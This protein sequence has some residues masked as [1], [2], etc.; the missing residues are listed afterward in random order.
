VAYFLLKK[1]RASQKGTLRDSKQGTLT[2]CWVKKGQV[3]TGNVN[4]QAKRT[5]ILLIAKRGTN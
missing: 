1:D 2:S 3:S 4:E 5:H